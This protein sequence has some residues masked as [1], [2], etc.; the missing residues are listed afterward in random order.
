MT[1][2]LLRWGTLQQPQPQQPHAT[3]TTTQTR[4][5]S[6]FLTITSV[7]K[8]FLL[9]HTHT[10]ADPSR[11]RQQN[12]SGRALGFPLCLMWIIS[13]YRYYSRESVRSWKQKQDASKCTVIWT[14]PLLGGKYVRSNCLN[15][16]TL[17]RNLTKPISSF[18]ERNNY[19]KK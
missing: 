10:I 15:P 3:L 7:N 16:V 12:H 5:D 17:K 11:R 2:R 4:V 6:L 1:L 9:H 18:S 19:D 14:S 13:V 8:S